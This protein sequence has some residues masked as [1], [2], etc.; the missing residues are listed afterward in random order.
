MEARN[1]RGRT[2][3]GEEG[4]AL[5]ISLSLAHCQHLFANFLSVFFVGVVE[6]NGTEYRDGKKRNFSFHFWKP[7]GRSPTMETE[8][9][10]ITKNDRRA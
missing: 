4:K 9:S 3:L 2:S 6:G 7:K 5:Y 10:T 1:A 8:A